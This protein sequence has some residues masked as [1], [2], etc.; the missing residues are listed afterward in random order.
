MRVRTLTI[1]ILLIFSISFILTAGGCSPGQFFDRADDL[2]RG[3]K[4]TEEAASS[5]QQTLDRFPEGTVEEGELAN[6]IASMLPD[7][8]QDR[9]TMLVTG[10][11]D[12]RAAAVDLSDQLNAFAALQKS[13]AIGLRE[14]GNKQASTFE[15]TVFGGLTILELLLGSTTGVGLVVGGVLNRLRSKASTA[16]MAAESEL[17]FQSGALRDLV[18]SIKASPKMQQAIEDGG[19]TELRQSMSPLTMGYIRKI[20]D[21]T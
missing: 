17:G 11:G 21:E 10:L 7:E 20:K 15:N 1:S 13:K 9:F 14:Q 8:W 5:I 2:D 3:A 4:I 19:G 12:T 16:R 18:T 6:A